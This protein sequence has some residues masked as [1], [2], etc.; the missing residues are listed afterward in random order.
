MKWNIHIQHPDLIVRYIKTKNKVRKIV[1]YSSNECDLRKKHEVIQ[2]FI[3]KNLIP[4]IFSKGYVAHRSIYSNAVSHI[5]ND[6]FIIGAMYTKV[7]KTNR[8]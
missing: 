1:A 3:D 6:Y 7:L 5:Y 4:S 8:W 2:K